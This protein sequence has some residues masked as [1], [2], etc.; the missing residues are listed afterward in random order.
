MGLHET[1][2]FIV[3]RI[4]LSPAHLSYCCYVPQAFTQTTLFNMAVNG[5]HS[6]L[7]CV[8]DAISLDFFKNK[9]CLS[10]NA[11]EKGL[12]YY[13]Q[14]Y[15]HKIAITQDNACISIAANCH[16]SMMKSKAPHCVRLVLDPKADHLSDA[17]CSC[18][19]GLALHKITY[20]FI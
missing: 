11:K 2:E 1:N 19:A 9:P 4:A 18:K 17:H 12:N 13:K 20:S 16:R 10:E 6:S 7:S 8:P 5:R 14:G 15:I 3:P